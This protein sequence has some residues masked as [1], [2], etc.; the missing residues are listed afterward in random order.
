MILL[1][2]SSGVRKTLSLNPEKTNLIILSRNR[3]AFFFSRVFKDNAIDRV[4]LVFALGVY[5]NSKLLFTAH[6]SKIGS[7]IRN[8]G[9]ITRLS[10]SLTSRLSVVPL[11]CCLVHTGLKLICICWNSLYLTRIKMTGNVQKCT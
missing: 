10:R 6:L 9:M 1:Q 11:L 3:K 4:P 7:A 8:L 2:F 5:I